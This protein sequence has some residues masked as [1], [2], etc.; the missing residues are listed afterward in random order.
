MS[1]CCSSSHR[2]SSRS[3]TPLHSAIHPPFCER[4]NE[5]RE[6]SASRRERGAKRWRE[7]GGERQTTLHVCIIFTWL[8]SFTRDPSLSAPLQQHFHAFMP[9]FCSRWAQNLKKS[10]FV[11]FASESHF[12][13][14]RF[15][16][17]FYYLSPSFPPFCFNFVQHL[18]GYGIFF[19]PL[20]KKNLFTHQCY[21]EIHTQL[22]MQI[23]RWLQEDT[24][25]G[26]SIITSKHKNTLTATTAQG[27]SCVDCQWN[28]V[29][30]E[31]FSNYIN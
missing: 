18:H 23:V 21:F 6:V 19:Q 4:S 7:T 2:P 9:S 3:F 15:S 16:L 24:K 1:V 17:L 20:V 8:H 26:G 13:I 5:W 30:S 29:A 28:S 14:F 10:Y 31:Y 12:I 27:E 25:E 11:V 22:H